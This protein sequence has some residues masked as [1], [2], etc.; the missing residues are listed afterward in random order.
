MTTPEHLTHVTLASP[1]GDLTLV[2]RAGQ[3]TGLYMAQQRHRPV[4]AEF[5]AEASLADEPFAS[6]AEQLAAYFSGELTVFDL[7]LAP[8]GTEFQQRIWSALRGIPYGQTTSYGDLARRVGSAS[9][10]VGLA[11]GRN[12]I[13]VII[14]CHR[15]IGAD[16]GLTGYGGGLDRKRYLL[17]LEAT[18]RQPTSISVSVRTGI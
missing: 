11:N 9:R 17:E 7:P 2:A 16:G 18:G 5:G 1:L 6:T 10:A 8:A 4:R 12:P 15:V 14:P 13:A 3:L